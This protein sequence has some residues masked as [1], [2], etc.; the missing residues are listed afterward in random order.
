MIQ[1]VYLQFKSSI[2]VATSSNFSYDSI[3][4]IHEAACRQHLPSKAC[5]QNKM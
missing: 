2:S 1:S 5:I 4:H 3:H